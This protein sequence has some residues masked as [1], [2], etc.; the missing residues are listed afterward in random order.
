MDE[1]K[2][3]AYG[4]GM[5]IEYYTKHYKSGP[6]NATVLIMFID[7]MPIKDRTVY[8]LEYRYLKSNESS[9]VFTTEMEIENNEQV[10]IVS[11]YKNRVLPKNGLF[12]AFVYFPIQ[13]N[14]QLSD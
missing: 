8:D 5:L 6:S 7:S 14:E 3:L 10:V 1:D 13:D 12:K 11:V 9:L 4:M 2:S